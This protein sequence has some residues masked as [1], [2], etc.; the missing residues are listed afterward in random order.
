MSRAPLAFRPQSDADRARLAEALA[1]APS[2]GAPVEAVALMEGLLG[3]AVDVWQASFT[4]RASADGALV[5]ARAAEASADAAWDAAV[6]PLAWS[7]RDPRGAPMSFTEVAGVA[8]S[9]AVRL[10]PFSAVQ[11]TASLVG[12]LN[13]G[14]GTADPAALA[15]LEA[16]AAA[17]GPAGQARAAAA[18]R[19]A[20]ATVALEAAEEA[21]DAAAVG[22]GRALRLVFGEDVARL[23]QPSFAG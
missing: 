2:S 17:L 13:A 15:A 11:L 23:L 20:Q 12:Q 19:R 7:L 1:A 21:L 4:E 9:R 22:T 8:P 14:A 18:E 10:S 6:E 5:A 16:A 3:G